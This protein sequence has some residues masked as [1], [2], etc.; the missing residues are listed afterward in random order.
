[1]TRRPPGPRLHRPRP[2]RDVRRQ[3]PRPH[4]RPARRRRQRRRHA[5]ACPARPAC[6]R[7]A[8]AET[9]VVPYNVVPELDDD[10]AA[11]DR[12]AGRRQH[13]RGRARRRASSTGCAPSATASAR[14]SIFDEVITGFR[15]G[16]GGAQAKYDVT[17]DLTTFGKVI[18]GGL[19]IGAVGGRRDVMEH[20]VAARPRVPR[21]HAV[22]ATRWPPPPASPRS[23]SSTT[24]CTSS[25]SARAAPPGRRAARRA[26]RPPGSPPSSR[27]S[28]RSSGIVLRRRHA[29]PS[30][31]TAPSAPT[32]RPTPRSSTPCSPRASRWP[33]APTR[34]SSSASATTTPSSTQIGEAAEGD[35]ARRAALPAQ[36]PAG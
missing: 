24:T 23:T 3:L 5:R 18:G 32:R 19:P 2:H 13:G 14:C 35:A 33:P 27:S 17:P 10:V 36:P 26:A 4:R 11:R 30:T 21:R 22:R 15:L 29:P 12:R 28:A 7:G 34:R 8:V 16:P 6:R 20:A 25:W 9:L 31:S 1:M